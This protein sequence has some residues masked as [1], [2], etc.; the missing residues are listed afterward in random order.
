MG[1]QIKRLVLAIRAKCSLKEARA[2]W[3]AKKCSVVAAGIHR[4]QAHRSDS[5]AAPTQIGSN[6]Y[7]DPTLI[8]LPKES[9]AGGSQIRWPLCAIR[10]KC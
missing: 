8:G 9:K 4:P 7:E 3:C 5:W 1:T 2:E 10:V 6:Y